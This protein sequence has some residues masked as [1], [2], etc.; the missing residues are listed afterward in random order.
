VELC[1]GLR[2]QNE[3]VNEI[4][5]QGWLEGFGEDRY[6]YLAFR[7]L[8]R[9]VYEGYFRSE[10]LD[11]LWSRLAKEI[12]N[13]FLP[14]RV[15]YGARNNAENLFI[16]DFGEPGSSA[17]GVP[18]T[19]R[20]SFQVK[21]DNVVSPKELVGAVRQHDDAVLLVLDDFIGSGSTVTNVLA[22]LLAALLAGSSSHPRRSVRS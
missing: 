1:D 7:M 14:V 8:Q 17:R 22:R 6:R 11:D 19:L 13:N 20:T 21:K 4:R 10:R 5:I 16:V 9:F 18:S 2:F 3:P 15:R 12:R